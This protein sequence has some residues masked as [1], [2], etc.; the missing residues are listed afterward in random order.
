VNELYQNLNLVLFLLYFSIG[1]KGQ[2]TELISNYFPITTYT[3]WSLYQYRVDFNPVQER[4]NIQRELL[5]AHNKFL[6][7]YICDGKMLFSIKQFESDVN[8][9]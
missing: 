7:A 4:T 5:S 9:L 6:G 3:D 2:P 1:S 8:F